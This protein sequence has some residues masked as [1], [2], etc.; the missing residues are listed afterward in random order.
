MLYLRSALWLCLL[1]ASPASHASLHIGDI[2]F[3]DLIQLL[4]LLLAIPAAPIFLVYAVW[5]AA[6]EPRV[7]RKDLSEHK[8]NFVEGLPV[9]AVGVCPSCKRDIPL[10]SPTC[11]GCEASFEAGAAWKVNPKFSRVSKREA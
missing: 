1:L 11:P 10:Q 7:A 8:R 9:E 6:R 4:V 5:R 2:G 3:W